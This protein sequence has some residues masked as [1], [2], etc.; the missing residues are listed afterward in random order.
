[1]RDKFPAV[2]TLMKGLRE[3]K[4]ISRSEESLNIWEPGDPDF[5]E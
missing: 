4:S 2:N 5:P 3:Q 1:M